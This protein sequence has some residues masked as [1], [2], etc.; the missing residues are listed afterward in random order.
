M[1]VEL[2]GVNNILKT[3]TISEVTSANGVTIDGL[4]IKDSKIVTANSVD[5]DV[6]VD[7]SIDTAHIADGQVTIG[8]L[9]TA[10]LTGATDIG[11][12]I[13]DADL[14]LV[15]DGAGG[16][17]RKTTAA[18]IKT[19]AGAS[20]DITAI[21]SILKADLKIGEDDQTKIDFETA[22]EIHFYA[23]NV[24][25]VYL[26]DNIFGPQSDSDVDLGTTGVR[27]KDAYIDTI[28]TTGA[29]LFPTLGVV[30]AKDLG[31]G[32][33]I[34]TSD[35]SGSVSANADNLVIEENGN[36]GLTLLSAN[37]GTGHI[38]FGNGGDQDEGFITYDSDNNRMRFGVNAAE[39]MRIRDDGELLIGGTASTNSKLM[40]TQANNQALA[41][42]HNTDSSASATLFKI[43]CD[44]STG[45]DYTSF[46]IDRAG[47]SALNIAGTGNVTNTNNSYGAISDERIKKDIT[48]AKSQ[49]NDIKAL[50]I[51]NY[52]LKT[53]DESPT[54]L[55]V[56]AQDLETDGM[57][58]LVQNSRPEAYLVN[59]HSDF[60]T[61]EDGTADNGATPIKDDDGKITG[62]EDLFTEG[63]KV[64]SVKY[65]VLYMKAIK[66]LQEAQTKIESLEARVTTL[67]G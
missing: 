57:G 33:H 64:K 21:D 4:N 63:K 47:N 30:T 40:V 48:D 37:N 15:D 52:K 28:T 10:V 23:N 1:S 17:L 9:A 66:C 11:A 50:K 34:R 54:Q 35:T 62:Y 16:T 67:E 44:N 56:I 49:W 7:G 51:K 38:F 18:R 59:S 32:I 58:G 31:T 22:D 43:K 24:E 53:D 60:G 42:F 36:V 29:S 41:R 13:V 39:M 20:G 8:K 55:G 6:Y 45:G 3:D 25:Q 14:F 65:S 61:I 12:A 46:N 26:A 2:D 5:S 19:Y 27:W